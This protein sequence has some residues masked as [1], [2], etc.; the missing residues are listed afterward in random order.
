MRQKGFQRAYHGAWLGKD[1]MLVT[2]VLE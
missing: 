1:D 2:D